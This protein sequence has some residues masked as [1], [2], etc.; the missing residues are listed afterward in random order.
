MLILCCGPDT[1]RATQRA[2]ELEAAFRAKH[3]PEG[4]SVDRLESGKRTADEVVER[5]LTVSLFSPMRFVRVDGLIEHCPMQKTKA[6]VQALSRDPERVIVVS[7]EKVK[8]TNAALKAF[9]DVPKLI[10]NE[11]PLLQGNEFFAWVQR[12]GAALGVMNASVLKTLA[13]ACDG[14]AWLASNELLKLAAGGVSESVRERET[15][16]YDV[17]DAFIATDPS[18]Y[19]RLAEKGMSDRTTYPLFQQACAALRVHDGDAQGLTSH[20]ISKMKRASMKRSAT[21]ASASVL[22]MMLSRSG[23]ADAEDLFTALP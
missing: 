8:P 16:T 1:Y 20:V 13:D 15:D 7:I 2:R 14:D 3:D 6:L 19:R 17:A 5:S 22:V 21:V 23:L 18:R 4:S 12:S 11:Y 10:V 9:A